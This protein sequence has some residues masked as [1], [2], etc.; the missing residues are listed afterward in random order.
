MSETVTEARPATKA[1]SVTFAFVKI[2]VRDLAAMEDFYKRA[3]GLEAAQ[4]VDLPDL[5]EKI[6]Q[7]PGGSGPNVILYLH[8]DGR[9]ITLGNGW[10]PVGFYVRDVDAAYAH[11]L[12]EGATPSR[13]PWD[14]GNLRVAFVLDP[15]G[16]EIELV[17]VKA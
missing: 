16:H 6:L 17:S 12:A 5:T 1:P 14:A 4:T 7:K 13:E 9:E 8:K 3:L 10:G 11:C 2:I 15:E